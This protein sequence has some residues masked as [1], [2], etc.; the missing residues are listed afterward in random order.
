ML[1]ERR[2]RDDHVSSLGE[3]NVMLVTNPVNLLQLRDM[4]IEHIRRNDRLGQST[5]NEFCQAL[6]RNGSA[7]VVPSHV[8]FA[9][10]SLHL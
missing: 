4:R 9:V 8:G 3:A 7:P 6:R 10:R 5:P 1:C 2:C